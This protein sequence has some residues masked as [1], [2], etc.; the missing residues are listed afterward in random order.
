MCLMCVEKV[1]RADNEFSFRFEQTE[2]PLIY[3][4]GNCPVG[5]WKYVAC[6]I[7]EQLRLEI[8]LGIIT[9]ACDLNSL[10]FTH[11]FIFVYS[12]TI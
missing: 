1:K 6:S 9:M 5:G 12:I 10:K 11:S 4:Y 7:K 3:S 8:D 2:V